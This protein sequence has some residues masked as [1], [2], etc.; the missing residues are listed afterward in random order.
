MR[1]NFKKGIQ[2]LHYRTP[3][4]FLKQSPLKNLLKKTK[5][6]YIVTKKYDSDK[7]SQSDH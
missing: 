7:T 1:M 6:S 4:W 5:T 3:R 2:S